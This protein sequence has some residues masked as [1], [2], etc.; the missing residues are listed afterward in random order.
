VALAG[1]GLFVL[2][3]HKALMIYSSPIVGFVGVEWWFLI[4]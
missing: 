3:G 2:L 1:G 4:L